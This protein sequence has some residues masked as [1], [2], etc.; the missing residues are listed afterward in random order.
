MASSGVWENVILAET[1]SFDGVKN[2]FLYNFLLFLIMAH[3]IAI[4]MGRCFYPCLVV[5][6]VVSLLFCVEDVK[7]LEGV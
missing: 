6:L 5:A 3:V 7:P 4:I 1:P 2:V